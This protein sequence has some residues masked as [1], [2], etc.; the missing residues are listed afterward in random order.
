MNNIYISIGLNCDVSIELRKRN[1]KTFTFPFDWNI[2]NYESIYL[3]LKD[4]FKHLFDKDKLLYTEFTDQYNKKN[5]IVVNTYYDFIFVHDFL[6]NEDNYDEVYKK[7]NRRIERFNQI[8]NDPNNNIFFVYDINLINE[9]SPVFMDFIN[10]VYNKYSLNLNKYNNEDNCNGFIKVKE[11]LL[12]LNSNIKFIEINEIIYEN[13]VNI[14]LDS[15]FL[16]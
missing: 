6:I 8:L 14:E 7:Y 12:N 13:I 1:I 10:N 2:K 16:D 9:L 11:L 15:L 3:L 5:K 4:N